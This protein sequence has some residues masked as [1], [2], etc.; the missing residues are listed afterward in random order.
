MKWV[1]GYTRDGGGQLLVR[2]QSALGSEALCT[3]PE[4]SADLEVEG[5]RPLR[6]M[7]LDLSTGVAASTTEYMT[8]LGLEGLSVDGQPVYEFLGAGR[9]LLVPA[10]LLVLAT[11]GSQKQLRRE[12]LSPEGPDALMTPMVRSGRL[13][14][15]P[16][17]FRSRSY[18]LQ[19]Q[20]NGPRLEWIQCYPS[21]RRAWTSVHFN[22]LHGRMNMSPIAATCEVNVRG[23]R[24]KDGTFLVTSLK[25]TEATP[26]E[27]PFEFARGLVASTYLFDTK[28]L[29]E[30]PN[31]GKGRAVRKEE[32]LTNV[33]WAGA[34]SDDQWAAVQPLLASFLKLDRK[35]FGRPARKYEVRDLVD[36]MLAKSILGVPWPQAHPE[37]R[38]VRTAIEMF[39]RLT[40]AG[41]WDQ[42]VQ[43]LSKGAA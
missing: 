25:L 17:A 29:V 12:L 7:S 2:V 31:G 38:R 23:I 22:A 9:R 6:R 5:A 30:R 19:P 15:E 34:M 35:D 28:K 13:S 3:L 10:Q 18:D 32:G 21:V 37:E 41:V 27:V 36:V 42:A 40:K 8:L 1:S 20:W 39:Y 14:M 11:V 26:N 43:T 4:L 33:S 16:T 24:A